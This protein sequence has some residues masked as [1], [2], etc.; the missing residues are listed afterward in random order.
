MFKRLSL[1]KKQ[2]RQCELKRIAEIAKLQ[3]RQETEKPWVVKRIVVACTQLTQKIFYKWRLNPSR[4]LRRFS[5]PPRPI[6]KKKREARRVSNK[7]VRF[8]DEAE[9][10]MEKAP[11]PFRLSKA[12]QLELFAKR[13]D[14]LAYARVHELAYQLSKSA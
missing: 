13:P 2:E 10:L 8:A 11:T 1:V 4:F 9:K 6:L 5:P 7:T 12:D 14:L 3:L